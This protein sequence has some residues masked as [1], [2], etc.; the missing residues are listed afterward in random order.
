MATYFVVA[1]RG[2][3][4]SARSSSGTA[5][6][7]PG[8][9]ARLAAVRITGVAAH[10]TSRRRNINREPMITSVIRIDQ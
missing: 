4:A 10:T 3:N 8:L 9:I 5:A 1:R 6:R 7:D 2:K